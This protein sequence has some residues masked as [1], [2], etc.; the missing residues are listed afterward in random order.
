[1]LAHDPGKRLA[2]SQMLSR[3]LVLYSLS[4]SSYRSKLGVG[5]WPGESRRKKKK[6]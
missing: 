5:G 4:A 3:R 2:I 6:K 1:M